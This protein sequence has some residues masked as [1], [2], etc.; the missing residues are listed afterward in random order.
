MYRA[1][2]EGFWESLYP[3]KKRMKG[4][5][6]ALEWWQDRVVES[7]ESLPKAAMLDEATKATLLQDVDAIDSFLEEQMEG[8][9]LLNDLKGRISG[10]PVPAAPKPEP[11]PTVESTPAMSSRQNVADIAEGILEDNPEKVLRK[12]LDT[13]RQAAGLMRQQDTGRVLA[14]RLS[15]LAAWSG[16]ESLPPAQD[17]KTKIP[18]PMKE[19]IGAL[20]KLYEQGN[21]AE[22]LEAAESRV[23]QYL[24]WL[25]LSRYAAESLE[26]LGHGAACQA[27]VE[28]TAR[29]ALKLKGVENLAFSDGT[30]FANG[31]TVGWLSDIVN[32]LTSGAGGDGGAR[33]GAA[34]DPE[35]EVIAETYA[36]AQALIK[37]KKPADAL[38]L[39]QGKLRAAGS[40]KHAM[41]WRLHLI[42]LLAGLRKSR[43][44]L[45]H[46]SEILIDL[47][48]HRVEEW[49]PDLALDALKQV[50]A[51]LKTQKDEPL[52]QQA[53]E[54]FDRIARIAPAVA[55]QVG[56]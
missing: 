20:E 36:R 29:Y 14:Y 8:A 9:P 53:A 16:I 7:L 51:V 56:P 52:K 48:Q 39:L 41:L 11:T 37:E 38:S 55:I 21:F 12:G 44:A 18:P 28:E 32:Q 54:V 4:R 50:Y 33:S 40:R 35:V 3:P 47:D 6:N 49:D 26:Q 31:A 22:L 45:P 34:A 1:L 15:R 46:M 24:F 5:K 13:L 25:D 42:R 10:I 43:L 27:I 2:L 23:S 17:G 19:F 30:P